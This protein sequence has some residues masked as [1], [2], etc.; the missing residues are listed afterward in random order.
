MMLIGALHLR[1]GAIAGGGVA[2]V[3]GLLVLAFGLLIFARPTR[4]RLGVAPE[5]TAG[6]LP[7][8][9]VMLAATS[10]ALASGATVVIA[11]A[12]R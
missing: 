11:E 2:F 3:P 5:R 12:S 4:H 8:S 6:S 1:L 9:L 10:I 7:V